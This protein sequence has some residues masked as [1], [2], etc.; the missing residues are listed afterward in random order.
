MLHLRKDCILFLYFVRLILAENSHYET[1]ARL[2]QELLREYNKNVLPVQH[3]ESAT[4]VSVKLTYFFQNL[5]EFDDKTGHLSICG[6]FAFSWEDKNLVWNSTENDDIQMIHLRK[7]TIWT[8][9]LTLMNPYYGYQ[10][11][12]L[13]QVDA[14]VYVYR[15]GLIFF[16]TI[17]VLDST[18]QADVTYFP[19][20]NQ[21]CQLKMSSWYYTDSE[22]KFEFDSE[23]D[24]NHE[25]AVEHGLWDVQNLRLE[26]LNY[27]QISLTVTFNRKPSFY[28]YNIILPINFICFLNIFV[29]R[30]PAVSGERTG[31]S[32]TML[33]SI[34]V[35]LTIVS[36]RLPESSNLSILGLILMLEFCMSGIILV[37]VIFGLRCYHTDSKENV[38]VCIQ[39]IIRLC[40]RR[41]KHFEIDDV[42]DWIRV[43]KLF[44]KVCFWM[45]MCIYVTVTLCYVIIYCKIF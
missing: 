34:A 23:G 8:P 38:P 31:F 39:Q 3:N 14:L 24:V 28:V 40:S 7:N 4:I 33:L 15:K 19:F 6:S 41:K 1:E 27:S 5:K 20:D 10:E 11:V 35:F 26:T 29:F 9:T 36:D 32:V 18:C 16:S 37:L 43:S 2:H 17:S 12:G 22:L 13:D 42:V 44:D 25:Y 30:L 45:F 21:V